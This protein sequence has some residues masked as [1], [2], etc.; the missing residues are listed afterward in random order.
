MDTNKMDSNNMFKRDDNKAL[1]VKV[2]NS[3]I[4]NERSIVWIKKIDECLSVC[5]KSVGWSD[6]ESHKI[7][8]I[9]NND[10]YIKFN[11]YFE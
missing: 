1:F 9:N 4:I 11:K 7:C 3:K 6:N 5:T 2:D 10:S 8:K